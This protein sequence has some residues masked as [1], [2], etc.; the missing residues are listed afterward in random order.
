LRRKLETIKGMTT[1]STTT[2]MMIGM[3]V[4]MISSW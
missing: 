2:A 3:N 4:S 1:S